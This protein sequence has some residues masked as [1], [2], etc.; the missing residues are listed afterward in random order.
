MRTVSFRE[1]ILQIGQIL[2]LLPYPQESFYKTPSAKLPA[3]LQGGTTIKDHLRNAARQDVTRHLCSFFPRWRKSLVNHINIDFGR[4]K[5]FSSWTYTNLH[6]EKNKGFGWYN[7]NIYDIIYIYPN[8]N[9]NISQKYIYIF[10][11]IYIIKKKATKTKTT[12]HLTSR[13]KPK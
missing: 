6:T 13:P 3:A 1:S 8:L 7:Q 2:S 12:S 4:K 11:Y 10:I 5:G 9:I